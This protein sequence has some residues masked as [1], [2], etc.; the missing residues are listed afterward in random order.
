M[1]VTGL[2]ES[3]LSPATAGPE[4]Q[5]QWPTPLS[6]EPFSCPA[7]P[8]KVCSWVV[9]LPGAYSAPG[10]LSSQWMLSSLRWGK[11]LCDF[12]PLEALRKYELNSLSLEPMDYRVVSHCLCP[13]LSELLSNLLSWRM[14]SGVLPVYL[15][16]WRPL[17]EPVPLS[18]PVPHPPTTTTLVLG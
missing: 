10:H 18:K 14:L 13:H 2:C 3:Q 6:V 8:F 15:G 7:L 4:G 9:L 5:A 16:T 11:A 17:L 12:P 1:S